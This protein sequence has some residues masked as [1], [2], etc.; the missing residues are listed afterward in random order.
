MTCCLI[1][2]SESN[3]FPE[4]PQFLTNPVQVCLFYLFILHAVEF[5]SVNFEYILTYTNSFMQTDR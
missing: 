5:G 1:A 3:L 2:V 4:H